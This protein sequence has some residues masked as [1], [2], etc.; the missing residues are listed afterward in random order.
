M[1]LNSA[2]VERPSRKELGRV[3]LE[4]QSMT[5]DWAPTFA[6]V[7]RAAFLP[8]LMWPFDMERGTSVC[9]DRRTDPGTWYAAADSD[10]P[11]VTQWDDGK[12]T[13]TAP[14]DVSTSSSSMP[15]VVY[16]MLLD[17]DLDAGMKALD[18]GTGTGETAGAL[19]HR[20]RGENVTTI[21]V[22][23][24][25]SARARERLC[26]AGLYPVVVMGDGFAGCAE[27]G[28]YD[29]ILATVGLREIPGAWIEQT[30]PGGLVVAPWGTHFSNADAVVRLVVKDGKA[31]G[32]FT[33]PVEFMKLRAQRLSRPDH[34]DYLA[35][36]S[37]NDADTSSTTI[38]EAE[39]VTGR[40]TAARFALGLRVPDCSQA[41]ADKRDGARPVWFY[42]LSDRS[43]ACVMF[44]DAEK[45]A[46]VWQSGPRRLW[47]ET[48][49]A[50]RW[51]VAQGGPEHTR[52]GLTVTQEGE[53]AWLD[54]PSQ[55]VRPRD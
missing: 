49:A 21:E 47:D 13:G 34:D 31:M 37:M 41:V 7:D 48:E 55:L 53:S 42:G 52:F 9:V 24:V 38:T 14:G 23:R 8:D 20:L 3:L 36:G 16:E 35:T 22:D 32:N 18:V 33:R 43:W 44:R 6:A 30:R 39:F 28:P 17:L 1:T 4:T 25:V 51:W 15:S 19:T 54:D 12:H 50:Y 27:R 29:R 45:E 26:A 46:R 10:I 2:Q 5:S 11:I 40:Y